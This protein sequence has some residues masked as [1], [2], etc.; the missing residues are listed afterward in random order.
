[1]IAINH[2]YPKGLSRGVNFGLSFALL[3]GQF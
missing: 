1:L 3:G 2:L